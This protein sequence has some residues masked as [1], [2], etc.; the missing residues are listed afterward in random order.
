MNEIDVKIQ[1]CR[2]WT[3][4]RPFGRY[5]SGWSAV[6]DGHYYSMTKVTMEYRTNRTIKNEAIET[7]MNHR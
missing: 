2:E 6:V 3:S 4:G 7:I 1:E 5:V